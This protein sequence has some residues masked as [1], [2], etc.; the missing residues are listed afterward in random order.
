MRTAFRNAVCAAV[1]AAGCGG[2]D[3][4]V[5]PP[6]PFPGASPFEYPAELLDL[7][8]VGETVLMVHVTTAGVVDSAY[9]LEPAAWSAFDS[10]ALAGARGLRFSP[11]RQG[12]RRIATWT[13][14][15]VRFAPDTS[16]A[17]GLTAPPPGSHQ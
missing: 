14:L 2:S 11:A 10:A 7:E 17:I 9:V 15:P 12:S 8:A 3:E 4:P 6:T 1:L 13:R 5:E 16:G